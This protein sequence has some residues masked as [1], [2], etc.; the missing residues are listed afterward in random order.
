MRLSACLL[1]LTSFV[2]IDA[3]PHP[4]VAG[5]VVEALSARDDLHKKYTGEPP[6]DRTIFVVISLFFTMVLSLLL[7]MCRARESG[8]Q[9]LTTYSGAR[10]NRLRKSAIMSRNITSMI[11]LI[12]YFLVFA[13]IFSSA[14]MLAGQG[15]FNHNLCFSAT[16][17]CLILYTACKGTM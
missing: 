10:F 12:L 8:T 16:W 14:I 3:M 9:S 4:P 17:I 1:L 7:G 11:V 5:S 6:T 13:F 15:L 2:A